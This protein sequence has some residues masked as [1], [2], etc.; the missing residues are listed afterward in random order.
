VSKLNGFRTSVRARRGSTLVMM[1]VCVIGLA[2][3]AVAMLT[4]GLSHSKE[5]RG[6][7]EEIHAS[8]VCQ[9][10]LSQA[11]YQLLRGQAG[12]VGTQANPQN[13]GTS[14]FWVAAQPVTADVTRLRATGK[15]N[16]SGASEELVVRRVVDS[17]WEYGLFG[18]EGL[19]MDSN[20]RVDSY[21]S[22][23]GTYAMQATNGSGSDMYALANGHVGS[24]GDMQLDANAQ[25]W[26]N[27]TPGPGHTTTI[28][29]NAEV[30]GST[31]P[32]TEQ[33]EMP[34]LN[35][36][37]YTS[38]GNLSVNGAGVTIPTGNRSYGQVLVRTNK[39]LTL[40]GPATIVMSSL[41]MESGAQIIVDSTNGP[42]T[43]YVLDN[44][45][46]DSNAVIRSTDYKPENVRINLLSDNVASPEITV[47]LDTVDFNS[48]SMVYGILFAPNARITLDSYFTLYGALM[49][50]SIDVDSNATFHFDED[51]INSTANAIIT[52]ETLSWRELPYQH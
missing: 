35:P 5:Q 2:G 29:G 24:N 14:S 45:I 42:V 31:T 1:L 49:A 26:G 33:L 38:Y 10:G 28:T 4:L 12:S 20:A 22:T 43:I 18:R 7:R 41:R 37:T 46:L 30:T 3:L 17:I 11:M 50:R 52:F 8:Y 44:F 51:L 9:A 27:A 36:P 15:D 47:Q 6:E 40:T 39:T 23:L 21:D 19:H 34:A 25:V 16:R 48:N 13:W 32:A